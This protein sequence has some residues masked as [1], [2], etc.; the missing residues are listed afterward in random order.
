MV[1]GLTREG[2]RA[3]LAP[4]ISLRALWGG[5]GSALSKAKQL[6]QNGVD[7]VRTFGQCVNNTVSLQVLAELL[8]LVV[9]CRCL[10]TKRY[11]QGESS[12]KTACSTILLY[13]L[14]L[15]LVYTTNWTTVC[16]DAFL[17]IFKTHQLGRRGGGT[18]RSKQ[19]ERKCQHA[20][21]E[22]REYAAQKEAPG[23]K[24]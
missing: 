16:G 21:T 7:C 23:R 13:C 17:F 10:V 22:G 12:W 2:P 1:V 3:S 18:E 11:C 6:R 4:H 8:L 9:D 15:A 14:L 19:P 24:H 20:V 5:E